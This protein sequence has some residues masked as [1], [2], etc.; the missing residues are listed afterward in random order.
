MNKIQ[1]INGKLGQISLKKKR[2]SKK[3]STLKGLRTKKLNSTNLEDI[4]D[5]IEKLV[6]EYS[7]LLEDEE[8]LLEERYLL[9]N[10][11]NDYDFVEEVKK[12]IIERDI[13]LNN[14]VFEFTNFL[15][16]FR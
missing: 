3:I 2:L 12:T 6:E 15:D 10:S 13:D 14:N 4:N 8:E 1:S 9:R 7:Y 5:K 11:Y 16:F